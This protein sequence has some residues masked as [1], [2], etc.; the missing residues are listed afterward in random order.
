MTN[1]QSQEPEGLLPVEQV[2]RE[3]AANVWRDHIAKLGECIAEKQI[4]AGNMM[5]ALPLTQAFA[6]HRLSAL[7]PQPNTEG[8]Q[9]VPKE[10]TMAMWA[11]GG[12]AVV[13][14]KNRH[15]DAVVEQVWQ[16]MLAAAP[17]PPEEGA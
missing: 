4:R 11:A 7:T 16:A 17:A 2:D 8:W 1:T 9:Y 15:H 6:H 5:D 3:A 13:G 14:Y 12:D 10:P